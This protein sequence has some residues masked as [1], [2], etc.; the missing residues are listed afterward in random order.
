MVEPN[1]PFSA[2]CGL[3][4]F[5]TN[6]SQLLQNSDPSLPRVSVLA[7]L[8]SSS[9][10]T[11]FL[12]LRCGAEAFS[13]PE[14]V[15]AIRNSSICSLEVKA[16]ERWPSELML[17][18]SESLCPG[19]QRLDL[20]YA[21]FSPEAIVA[22]ESA[23]KRCAPHGLRSIRLSDCKVAS[24]EEFV[25]ALDRAREVES[26][27]FRSVSLGDEDLAKLIERMDKLEELSLHKCDIGTRCVAA[28]GQRT[29]LS[30]LD[31]GDS[32]LGEPLSSE[33][34]SK[35][36]IRGLK[37][38]SLSHCKAETMAVAPLLKRTPRLSSLNLFGNYFDVATAGTIGEG[39]RDSDCAKTLRE[40]DVGYCFR[41]QAEVTSFF[42]P[43][44]GITGLT[45]L[46]MNGN[47]AEDLGAKMALECLLP[48]GIEKLSMAD[49]RITAESAGHLAK[50]L[51]RTS[52]ISALDLKNNKLC[53]EGAAAVIMALTSPGRLPIDT[54]DLLRCEIGDQGAE[55]VGKLIA[56]VGCRNLLIAYNHIHAAGA[57]AIANSCKKAATEIEYLYLSGNPIEAEGVKCIAEQIVRANTA[58]GILL[59]GEI[60]IDDETAKT[61]ARAIRER[62]R[63][64]P[65]SHLNLMGACFTEEGMTAMQEVQKLE[66][67][68]DMIRL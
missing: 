17:A 21:E 34:A 51:L 24:G 8:L 13:S 41:G 5:V 38:L 3:I 32:P 45:S 53:P 54:L 30:T 36:Q 66:H 11:E 4:S 10:E 2:L 12:R 63:E 27:C 55:A 43:L 14:F 50:L 67:D 61:L 20:S 46:S 60:K 25:A 15:R 39:I 9:A 49:N 58:V 31:L 16:Y 56:S 18:I 48:P 35:F 64:G 29:C 28:I 42:A 47:D 62:N 6:S 1:D 22:F 59:L 37:R 52:A 26:V 7:S 19:L 57:S 44:S 33:L 65:L 40:L 23:L 68:T